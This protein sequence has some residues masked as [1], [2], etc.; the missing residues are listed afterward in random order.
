MPQRLSKS[1][2]ATVFFSQVEA[3]QVRQFCLVLHSSV[4]VELISE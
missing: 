3:Q 1:D 2:A 4:Q